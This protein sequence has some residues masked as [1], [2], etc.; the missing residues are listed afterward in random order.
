[1]EAIVYW[2]HPVNPAPRSRYGASSGFL[3]WLVA[4]AALLPPPAMRR[5]GIGRTLRTKRI[6]RQ[7]AAMTETPHTRPGPAAAES[8][9]RGYVYWTAGAVLL[10]VL[11]A[12][13]SVLTKRPWCDEA[14]FASPALDL[15]VN[16]RMGTHV[17]E[18]TGTAL[19]VLKS[20]ARLDRIDQHTYWVMP[21]HFLVLAV[22]FKIF[23]FSLTVLRLPAVVWGLAALAAWYAMVRRLG[24]SRELAALTLFFIGID[25]AFVNSASDGRMD[26]MCASLGFLAM[27]VYLALRETRFPWAVLLSHAAAALS[28]FTHPN[29]V[30]A[31]VSLLFMMFY[32][33]R[34]RLSFAVLPLAGVPYA[35]AA[36]GWAA[37]I[38][39]DRAAFVAQF[40]ANA[41]DRSAGLLAP[42]EGL[43]LEI[44]RRYLE[45]HFLPAAGFSGR[46]KVLIL[47]GYVAALA[48]TVA[49]PALRRL[50]GCRLLLYLTGLR[51]LMMAWGISV[52]AD[53]YLVHIV[54]FY[55]F[56][57]ACAACWLW[58]R[59]NRVRWI[60]AL[61][62]CLVVGLQLSWS[63]YR[64]FWL[65]PYQKQYLPAVRFLKARI[66]PQDLVC[67][68]AELAFAFGFYN[69]QIVDDIWI[70]L[71]SGKRP[72]ILVVDKWYYYQEFAGPHKA[73]PAYFPYVTRLLQDDFKEI[74]SQADEYQIYARKPGTV[75]R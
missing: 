18:P 3:D 1:M 70:G 13:G 31:S 52:K 67:G 71:W 2:L 50:P 36:L 26:M 30:L 56:F 44:A 4:G 11:L 35:I 65:R 69:P 16:G 23:G 74:Y 22:W 12:L 20:G 37:Y 9:N 63:L 51:F 54:P 53:Y 58:Q 24:G 28:V 10:F 32:L 29:G 42:V 5:A 62:L 25:F 64:I 33:D 59:S 55:A 7:V 14:W 73:A 19:S 43:R 41:I 57:M 47:L 27:A 34:K 15:T 6:C 38:M 40:G 60:T 17:L 72:T 68:S 61:L 21:L 49:A 39:R 48:I 75:S 46:L 8:G 66:T 45:G